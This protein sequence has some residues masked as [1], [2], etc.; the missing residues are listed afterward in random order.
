MIREL[1]NIVTVSGFLTRERDRT[2]L[3]PQAYPWAGIERK[4]YEGVRRDVLA[5]A[6]VEEPIRIEHIRYSGLLSAPRPLGKQKK[7]TIRTP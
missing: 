4:E 1:K 2:Y 3:L 7:Q 6:V 5:N